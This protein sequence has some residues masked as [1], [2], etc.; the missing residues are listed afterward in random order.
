MVAC[1]A[2]QISSVSGTDSNNYKALQIP[3]T[4]SY[5]FFM[6]SQMNKTKDPTPVAKPAIDD[7]V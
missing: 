1:Q 5:N 2:L 4:K 3:G 7:I 6:N